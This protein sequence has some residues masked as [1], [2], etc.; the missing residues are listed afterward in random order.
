MIATLESGSN[1]GA[2]V[3]AR[4]RAA[5]Y[6]RISPRPNKD[7]LGVKRQERAG[8]ELCRRLGL[9]VV[10]VFE[11]DDRSA[12]TGKPRPGYIEMMERLELG[13]FGVIVAWDPD[14]L[15]RSLKE[16]EEFIDV[17]DRCKAMVV[18][19]NSGDYDLATAG[20]RMTARVVGTVARHESEHKSERIKAKFRELVEAGKPLGGGGSRAYGH[21]AHEKGAAVCPVRP[22]EAEI[23]RELVR[24]YLAGEAI[25]GLA[26]GL[27]ARKVPTVSGVAWRQVT[28]RQILRSPRIAGLREY[29]G[30]L[31]PAHWAKIIDPDEYHRMRARLDESAQ[32]GR[33]APRRFLLTG[34]A[35][36]GR[37]DC[38]RPLSGKTVK[39]WPSDD[40][41]ARYVCR[42]DLGGCGRLSVLAVPVEDRV[43]ELLFDNVDSP[44]FGSRLARSDGQPAELH[45]QIEALE[46]RMDELAETYG[47]GEITKREWIRAR[48]PLES[49]LKALRE[50][51]QRRTVDQAR[52]TVLDRW[53]DGDRSLAAD[54][55]S[56]RLDQ[57]RAIVVGALKS[58]VIAPSDAPGARRFDSRRVD[59]ERRF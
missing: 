32:A 4:K 52:S 3:A 8:R 59:V 45:D 42:K 49:K 11:D 34:I 43:K 40:T 29:E 44:D 16:L 39:K 21:E 5:I 18:T 46:R 48:T 28:V 37:P 7:G 50:A 14:R 17:V 20:G 57:Q 1:S 22:D 54:W 33:R 41:E 35:V 30:Q 2:A 36:C 58:I 25:N 51:N 6:V 9:T 24:R 56:L 27:N 23:V 26:A 19:A 10:A 15:H 31:V 55:P 38:G 12:Y 13:D 53:K 47:A